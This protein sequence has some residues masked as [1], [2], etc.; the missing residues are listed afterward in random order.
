MAALEAIRWQD[1]TLTILDQRVLPHQSKYI[2]IKNSGDG[3]DAI[4][5]M[6][7]RG[8][9]AI[10]IVGAL[11]VAAE[12]YNQAEISSH[13]V[14]NLLKDVGESRPTAVNLGNAIHDLTKLV[15]M[16]QKNGNNV[17]DAYIDAATQMLADDVADNHAIGKNGCDWLSN[18]FKDEKLSVITHCNT[19]SLATAGFGTALGIVRALHASNILLKCFFTE[20]RPYNQG[21]RLTG[22]ELEYEH[23]PAMLITD[24]MAS[25]LMRIDRTVK[26]VIVGADRVISTGGT[27]NKIGTYQLAIAARYHSIKFIVAAPFSTLDLT[28]HDP[29]E[30]TIEQ[31][32]QS[33]ATTVRGPTMDNMG[34]AGTE[35]VTISSAAPGVAAWNP[36]FD[37]TPPEL[38]DAIV[39][40][41]SVYVRENNRFYFS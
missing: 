18:T 15:N 8:A 25:A 12:I 16:A 3:I 26:A 19:G 5:S 2:G 9:P 32:N 1:G 7:V 6:A 23:I 39:T 41:K 28:C 27:F 40:E 33:E 21:A 38:I 24:S 20:T 11:A 36:A 13:T 17:R 14:I 35:L 37:Y 30:I 29:N 4:K 10:A 34:Q 22:Y 31:R